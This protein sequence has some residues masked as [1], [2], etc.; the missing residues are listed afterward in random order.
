MPRCHYYGQGLQAVVP[1]AIGAL[2]DLPDPEPAPRMFGALA[3][4]DIVGPLVHHRNLQFASYDGLKDRV[5]CCFASAARAVLISAD[6]IGGDFVG[7]LD[8]GR[9]LMAMS[10]AAGKDLYWYVDGQTMSSGVS[11]ACAA[12]RI[13]CPPGGFF[14]SIGVY[15]SRKDETIADRAMGQK[16][17]IV[18]SG[19]RKLDQNPHVAMSEDAVAEMRA[20]VDTTSRL[21]FDWVSERRGVDVNTLSDLQG[22]IVFGREALALGL[23]DELASFDEAVAALAASLESNALAGQGAAKTMTPEER[24][25]MMASLA[26]AAE[27]GDEQAKKALA[28]FG[29]PEGDEKKK[30]EEAKAKAAADAE[31]K[32]KQ[33]AAAKAKAAEGG[34]EHKEPDGDE[35][36]AMAR[37]AIAASSAVT[38]RLDRQEVTTMLSARSDLPSEMRDE[39]M[40]LPP[41]V[42]RGLLAK[43]P[44]FPKAQS[45]VVAA[46]AALTVGATAT[47]AVTSGGPSDDV[48]LNAMMGICENLPVVERTETGV[49]F[50][51]ATPDRARSAHAAY[52]KAQAAALGAN[53]EVVS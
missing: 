23:V 2:F 5:A 46:R 16:W 26:K 53:G 35:A 12:K 45:P 31:D 22:R 14:G 27:E 3:V 13:F 19:E 38:T 10:Q 25:A 21:F 47:G 51:A 42:V 30:D 44:L 43:T 28:A 37:Q 49:V 52:L 8:T 36:K 11:L 39:L 50:R 7:M 40:G 18:S 9:E 4:V 15:F 17:T 29:E 32:E 34:G 1:S 48:D 24:K 20:H 33:E 41:S 6:T